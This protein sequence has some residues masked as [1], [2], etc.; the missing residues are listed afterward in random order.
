MRQMGR[1]HFNLML[2]CSSLRLS[3]N[4]VQFYRLGNQGINAFVVCLYSWNSGLFSK[5]FSNSGI[6]ETKRSR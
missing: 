1:V 6:P 2:A 5:G 3:R 4:G